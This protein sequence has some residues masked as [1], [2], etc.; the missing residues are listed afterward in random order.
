MKRDQLYG[1]AMRPQENQ[2]EMG[3]DPV[4]QPRDDT[5]PP[6]HVGQLGR[7]NGLLVT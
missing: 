2:G 1:W 6:R 5:K 7:A 3:G 4:F